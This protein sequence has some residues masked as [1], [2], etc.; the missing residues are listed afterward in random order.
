MKRFYF[1]LQGKQNVSDPG[2][3]L[4]DCE[5]QAIQAAERLAAELAS[6][7]PDLRGNTSLVVRAKDDSERHHIFVSDGAAVELTGSQSDECVQEA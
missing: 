6:S 3:L 1:D 5:L 2:G 7:R 4:F